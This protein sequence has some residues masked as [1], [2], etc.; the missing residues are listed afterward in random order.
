LLV[1]R[2]FERLEQF[3]KRARHGLH[4]H[5]YRLGIDE[6]WPEDIAGPQ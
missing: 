1:D 3:E 5:R 2:G 6:L 4:C